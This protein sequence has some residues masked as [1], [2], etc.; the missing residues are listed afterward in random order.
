MCPPIGFRA[1]PA[2]KVMV[3]PG[4]ASQRSSVTSSRLTKY[5]QPLHWTWFVS[6]MAI[7]AEGNYS[8][9]TKGRRTHVVF[10][11][12]LAQ[13]GKHLGDSLFED[14]LLV[15]RTSLTVASFCCLSLNSPRPE[16]SVRNSAMIESII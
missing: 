16:K 3:A 4:S 2:T 9:S 1:P 5:C 7:Y 6:S 15:S 11:R 12:D 8:R 14:L 10:F 13:L